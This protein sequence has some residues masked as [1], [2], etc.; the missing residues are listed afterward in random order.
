MGVNH[1]TLE[2]S[3]N[4]QKYGDE[5]ISTNTILGKTIFTSEQSTVDMII[6]KN[7]ALSEDSWLGLNLIQAKGAIWFNQ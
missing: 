6:N 1:V 3:F 5:M 7:V 2:S 4:T